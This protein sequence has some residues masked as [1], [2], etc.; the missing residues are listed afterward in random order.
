MNA[1]ALI[2]E[3]RTLGTAKLDPTQRSALG[4][5]MTPAQIAHFM[6]G[7]FTMKPRM[8]VLDAGA[9][10][11]S[12]SVALIDRAFKSKKREVEIEAWEIE[13]VLQKILQKGFDKYFLKNGGRLQVKVHSGDF[14]EEGSS[15]TANPDYTGFTHAILNPPYKKLGS[16]SDHRKFLRSAGIETV[17]L[18][19]GFTALAIQ[20]LQQK[21]E[22]VVIIPRSFC[23]G[24]YYRP[25]RD[26]LIDQCSIKQIHLFESRSSAFK[27][28]DVLQENIIVHAIK[29]VSQEEVK[30][31]TSYGINISENLEEKHFPFSEIVQP[32]DSERFIRIP[33]CDNKDYLSPK[34]CTSSLEELG[35][36]V[37]TGPVVDFRLKEHLRPTFDAHSS[38]VPLLYPHHFEQQNFVWPKEHKKPN[39]IIDNGET[40]KWLIPK[41]NYVLVKRFSSKEEKRRVVAYFLKSRDLPKP[42]VG[43]ENHWNVF[44]VKKNG[45]DKNFAKGLCLFLNSTILDKHF[46]VFSGHT[47][48]NATDL[49][50]I[51]YPSRE[52]LENLGK[53]VSKIPSDQVSVDKLV[54]A[55]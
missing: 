39:A 20:L 3:S 28:D 34:I 1:T 51:K 22:L 44:H 9:G 13:P 32:S 15:L 38:C 46:R 43:L 11:G 18:Y 19:A 40:R 5:F 10:T 37:S 54:E 55:L 33:S 27:D 2:E 29:G 23:N 47:Q 4:Q 8:R 36:S 7:L 6:A 35:V 17:N 14:I 24:P 25:F 30:V 52:K 41:G 48:V 42:F 53:Q 16:Y 12:L 45:L 50:S 26:L 21:G 31:T 49:R